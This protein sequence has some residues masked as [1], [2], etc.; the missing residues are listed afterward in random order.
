MSQRVIVAAALLT[1]LGCLITADLKPAQA[2]PGSMI[3]KG[4]QGVNSDRPDA[5][6]GG[7][8]AIGFGLLGAVVNSRK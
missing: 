8:I 5:V 1:A 4:I 3:A 2:T 6:I 7:V